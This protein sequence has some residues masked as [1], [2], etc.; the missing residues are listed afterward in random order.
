MRQRCAHRDL[1][2]RYIKARSA[3]GPGILLAL[4]AETVYECRWDP[5]ISVAFYKP[6]RVGACKSAAA[7]P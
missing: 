2:V 7:L 3:A 4:H 5:S 1:T 6:Q